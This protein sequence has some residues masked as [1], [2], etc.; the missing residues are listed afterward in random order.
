MINI[1][2]LG[3]I[4]EPYLN[5]LID[6]YKKRIGKYHKINIIELKDENDLKAEA[7]NILKNIDSK[8]YCIVCDIYGEQ[9]DSR[10]LAFVIDKIF[11]KSGTIDFVIG[12]S[13]GLDESVKDRADML[14]SFS[15]FT[16]PHGLFRGVLLEQIYR[17]FKI[18]NN[19]TYHK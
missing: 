3:K 6:D 12:S 18:N 14:L 2:C 1:I 19:E 17:V 13:E 15:T 9:M 11:L 10:E 8:D 5:E 16:M 4:K 7:K